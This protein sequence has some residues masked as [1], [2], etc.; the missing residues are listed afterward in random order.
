MRSASTGRFS[1]QL[2]ACSLTP[3]ASLGVFYILHNAENMDELRL[4]PFTVALPYTGWGKHILVDFC[5]IV[6]A[7][8]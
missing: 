2:V 4:G 6:P 3:E 8:S 7:S 1:Y 5:Q